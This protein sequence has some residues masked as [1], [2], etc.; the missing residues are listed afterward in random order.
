MRIKGQRKA[1]NFDKVIVAWG[2]TQKKLKQH[3]SNVHYIEDRFSH[4]KIH[5]ELIRAKDVVILGDTIDSFQVAQATRDYLDQC[6]FFETKVTLMTTEKPQ[7]RT[8]LGDG[9]E[10]VFKKQLRAQRISYLPNVKINN[11]KGDSELEGIYFNK[12]EDYGPN[13]IPDTE[14]FMQ[15]DLVICSN[16]I[17]APRRDLQLLVGAQQEGSEA[18][19]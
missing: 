10:K 3:Y 6:G 11:F 7:V 13:K 19:I 4:A 14:Y 15:P 9:I 17:D 18:K 8:T 1:L 2:A 12:E 5:N 16:G